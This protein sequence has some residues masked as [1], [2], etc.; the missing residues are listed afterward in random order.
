MYPELKFRRN[1]DYLFVI[2]RIER[3]ENVNHF[4]LRFQGRETHPGW[5]ARGWKLSVPVSKNQEMYP[6]ESFIGKQI[7][8]KVKA[9]KKFGFPI[10]EQAIAR[11][12]GDQRKIK[13]LNGCF[14]PSRRADL[15]ALKPKAITLITEQGHIV[16]H[17]PIPDSTIKEEEKVVVQEDERL[18]ENASQNE[19]VAI[20]EE[21]EKFN[22]LLLDAAAGNVEAQ[23]EV[24]LCYRDGIGVTQ[25]YE[26]AIEWCIESA[27]GGFSRAA[28]ALY[29]LGEFFEHGTGVPCDVERALFFYQISAEQNLF[30][31][32]LKLAELYEQGKCG[33]VDLEQAMHWYQCAALNGHVESCYKLGVY[34][35]S[36]V[37]EAYDEP[38]SFKWFKAAAD[39]GHK[40]GAFHVALSYLSGRCVEQ[41]GS[42]AVGY[43]EKIADA[44][45]DEGL[46]MLGLCY[47]DGYFTNKN[48]QKAFDLFK[49]AAENGH[50][51]SA[52]RVAECYE[53]ARGVEQDYRQAYEWY[54]KAADE[55]DPQAVTALCSPQWIVRQMSI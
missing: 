6:L 18:I 5:A 40:E 37:K 32:Q 49:R 17:V 24:S 23:Y 35:F 50:I 27:K 21:E 38:L 3:I 30:E 22:M 48:E 54:V 51:A 11:Y 44:D 19:S 52:F 20:S 12:K 14:E 2:G 1:I 43:L 13:F 39:G 41:S 8:C 29:V 9:Y 33:G 34:H 53:Y 15:L 26:K 42:R 55:G 10:L 31:A 28:Y 25:D 47:L 16:E 7:K 4:V 45:I 36:S 46:Y